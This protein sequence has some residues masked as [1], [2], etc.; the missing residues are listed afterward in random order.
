MGSGG[1]LSRDYPDESQRPYRMHRRSENIDDTRLKIVEATVEL[2]STVGPSATTVMGIADKAGVTRATVYRHFP[3]DLSL[4][5]ACSMHWLSQQVRP[6]P[7]AWVNITGAEDR[8][9]AGLADLYRFYRNGESMLTLIYRD[10]DYLPAEHQRELQE[11]ADHHRDVLLAAF[12][13]RTRA[14]HRLR[15]IVGH[16]VSF[17][18]WRSLCINNKLTNKAAIDAM[19]DLAMKTEKRVK[20]PQILKGG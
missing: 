12:P 4:V 8:L 5:N 20:I 13:E 19:V 17:W 9:R 16:V 15:A 11:R 6:R 2:H 7:D 18:T 14:G 3:D 10:F 1:T